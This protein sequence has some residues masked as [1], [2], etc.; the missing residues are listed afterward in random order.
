VGGRQLTSSW[1]VEDLSMNWTNWTA[2]LLGTLTV[3]IA[4]VEFGLP[5]EA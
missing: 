4:R 1:D 3:D 2:L 5:R